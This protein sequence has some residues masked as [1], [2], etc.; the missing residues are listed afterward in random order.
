MQSWQNSQSHVTFFS[1]IKKMDIMD[2]NKKK[3][4]KWK[5]YQKKVGLGTT[6]KITPLFNGLPMY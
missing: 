4:D 3:S 5:E 1:L 6:L 2:N